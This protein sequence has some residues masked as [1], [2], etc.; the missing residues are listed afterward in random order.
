MSEVMYN[1]W[2]S[3]SARALHT[4][5]TRI[6]FFNLKAFFFVVEYILGMGGG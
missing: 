2:F 4:G 1:L 3:E 6:S 5:K